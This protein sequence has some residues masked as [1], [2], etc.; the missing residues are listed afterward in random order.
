MDYNVN[1]V[2]KAHELFNRNHISANIQQADVEYLPYKNDSF[3]SIINTMAFTGYP[4]GAKALSEIRRI[5]KPGGKLIMVD[6]DYPTSKKG[7][8]VFMTRF[9]I[10][11]GDV[12]RDMQRLFQETDFIF[13][14]KEIGGWGS[15]HLYIA[16]KK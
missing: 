8:G 15:V 10:A 14:D 1:F 13:T 11:L 2:S 5:L 16:Q 6:I 3:D 7:I 9:W 12:V 4:N